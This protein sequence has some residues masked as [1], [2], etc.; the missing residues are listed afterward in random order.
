MMLL[1]LYVCFCWI[2]EQQRNRV[3]ESNYTQSWINSIYP[4]S[5]LSLPPLSLLPRHS[6]CMSFIQFFSI[7]L[8]TWIRY[9]K[10]KIYIYFN[11][12]NIQLATLKN[13]I[14]EYDRKKHSWKG[15]FFLLNIFQVSGLEK[16]QNLHVI[17]LIFNTVHDPKIIKRTK[18]GKKEN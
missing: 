13:D 8:L 6:L 9:L 3:R 12:H 18:E 2:K 4:N 5:L 7:F 1:D 17:C 15:N 10:M 11:H 16:C 14:Y